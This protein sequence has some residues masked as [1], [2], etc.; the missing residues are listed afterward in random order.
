MQFVAFLALILVASFSVN[1][2]G[3]CD[4]FHDPNNS[5]NIIT[6]SP[7]QVTVSTS[8]SFT[9]AT[10]QVNARTPETLYESTNT[11]GLDGGVVAA[12]QF[13]VTWA[14]FTLFYGAIAVVVYM[15]TTASLQIEWL[16]NYLVIIVSYS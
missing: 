14:V 2:T 13:F 9:V 12:S 4:E 11:T 16:V 1:H 10:T 5:S 7:L 8:Y 6:G 3:T 15:L